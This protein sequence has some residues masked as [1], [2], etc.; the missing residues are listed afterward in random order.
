MCSQ[1]TDVIVPWNQVTAC[2][3]LRGNAKWQRSPV[4]SSQCIAKENPNCNAIGEQHFVNR[5]RPVN[6]RLDGRR[7]VVIGD[8]AIECCINGQSSRRRRCRCY[9]LQVTPLTSVII[10]TH[11]IVVRATGIQAGYDP[12]CHIA[13]VQ[14]MYLST[15]LL[16]E[17]LGETSRI[18]LGVAYDLPRRHDAAACRRRR[19]DS[20]NLRGKLVRIWKLNL[21]LRIRPRSVRQRISLEWKTPRKEY[22]A[23]AHRRH[24]HAQQVPAPD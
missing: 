4:W 15:K 5:D 2:D 22:L 24:R 17:S 20:F 3:T 7:V 19:R 1:S 11:S 14:V 18:A 6:H 16:N 10:R 12:P 13:D 9:C 21:G 8:G 23:P